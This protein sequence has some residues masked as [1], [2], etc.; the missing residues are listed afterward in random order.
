MQKDTPIAAKFSV[1][2]LNYH[3]HTCNHNRVVVARKHHA[4]LLIVEYETGTNTMEIML[5]AQ[6]S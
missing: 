3:A 4:L 1:R 2:T 6:R 5:M